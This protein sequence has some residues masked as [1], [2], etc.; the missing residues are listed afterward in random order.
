M[1]TRRDGWSKAQIALT[2]LAS[3]VAIMTTGITVAIKAGALVYATK[4]DLRVFQSQVAAQF[5]TQAARDAEQATK[6][7]IILGARQRV[8][9]PL[10]DRA[11]ASRR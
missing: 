2:I 7:D 9:E 1:T 10:P 4:D 8:N 6:L 11:G 5:A 3:V